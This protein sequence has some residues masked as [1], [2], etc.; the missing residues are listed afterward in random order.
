MLLTL[1]I[2]QRVHLE[3]TKKINSFTRIIQPRQDIEEKKRGFVVEEVFVISHGLLYFHFGTEPTDS[4]QVILSSGLLSAIRDFSEGTRSSNLDQFSTSTEFFLF[5]KCCTSDKV[6]VGV[7]S[8]DTSE[9]LARK[10]LAQVNTIISESP[11]AQETHPKPDAPD[12]G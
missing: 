9:S 6:I 12:S 2:H 3:K 10:A 8:R 11:L 1:Q 7:F 4:D 5:E